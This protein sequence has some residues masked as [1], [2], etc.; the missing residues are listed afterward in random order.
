MLPPETGSIASLY[1]SEAA[2]FSWLIISAP[3]IYQTHPSTRH[4]SRNRPS[5]YRILPDG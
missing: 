5:F 2:A 1:L 4:L 3:I